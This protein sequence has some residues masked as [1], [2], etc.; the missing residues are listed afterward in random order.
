MTIKAN[1]FREI[2][3]AAQEEPDQQQFLAAYGL[4]LWITEEVTADEEAA[5]E[6]LKTIH[7]VTNMVPEELI[8]AA[9]LTQTTFSR[10]FGIPLRSV[11][12]WCGC[13][14]R[15]PMPEYL[16]F[17]AAELLGLLPNIQIQV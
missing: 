6:L 8:A 11:Q 17:M 5:V 12:N 9:G 2:V 4:P 14:Q 10:R 3:A 16:K 7:G 13:G 1:R 15:R